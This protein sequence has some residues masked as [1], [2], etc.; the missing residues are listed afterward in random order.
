M[1]TYLLKIFEVLT[2]ELHFT[3]EM[4][5]LLKVLFERPFENFGLYL[6]TRGMCGPINQ[7]IDNITP[8]V[9]NEM[10]CAN[11]QEWG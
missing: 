9:E 3:I 5:K 11:A 6:E 2:K 4:A 7:R 8:H 10:E 1:A